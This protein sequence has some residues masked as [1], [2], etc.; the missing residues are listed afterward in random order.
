MKS[1]RIILG[2]AA[3]CIAISSFANELSFC[4]NGFFADTVTNIQFEPKKY[5]SGWQLAMPS[6]DSVIF[7][8]PIFPGYKLPKEKNSAVD[9]E[10]KTVAMDSYCEEYKAS[11]KTS[12]RQVNGTVIADISYKSELE[13]PA[14]E[15]VKYRILL[16]VKIFAG[17][18]FIVDGKKMAFPEE[19]GTNYILNQGKAA[20]EFRFS[21]DAENEL[22]IKVLSSDISYNIADCR[23]HGKPETDFHLYMNLKDDKFSFQM[24]LLKK[25][26]QFP[27]L[28]ASSVTKQVLI[29]KNLLGAGSGFEVG[30]HGINP[31][32]VYSWSEAWTSPAVQPAFDDSDA[33]SGKY[34]LLIT[35]EDIKAKR[36]RFNF[37]M[38]ES[39]PLKLDP[40]KTYTLSAWMKSDSD[41]MRAS[42]DCRENGSWDGTSGISFNVG[43]DWK[44]YSYTFKPAKFNV[45]NY[46]KTWAGIHPAVS[47]GKLWIDNMQLEEGEL[48]EYM[49]EALEFGAQIQQKHKL[50]SKSEL[51][52]GE[53]SLFF[54]NNSKEK[55]DLSI[56]YLIKDYWD[57]NLAEGKLDFSIQA[58]SNLK[59]SMKIPQLPC[60]Y[61]RIYFKSK[62]ANLSDELIFGVY[63]PMEYDGF[64][65][66]DWALGCDAADGNPIVRKLGFG[67]T[68]SWDFT[69]KRT[70]PEEG[71]LNFEETDIVMKNCQDAKL[72]IMPILGSGFGRASYDKNGNAFIPEWA[73]ERVAKSSVKNSWALD[74]SF[75]RLE[76]WSFYVKTLAERYKGKI[77]YWEIMNEPN[78]WISPEEYLPYLESASK[79]AKTVDSSSKIV[80]GCATSDWGGEPAPWTK[81]VL[82]LD[83]GRSMDVLSIHMYSNVAPERSLVNG[84]D[85]MIAVLQ[86][87]M[88]QYGKVLPVWHTEK[89]HNTK[90][91]GYSAEKIN[92]PGAYLHEP[93]FCVPDFRA[94]AE[95]LIRETLID[96][97][98]GKGPFFWFGNMPNDIYIMSHRS[99]YGLQHIEYDGSPC[100][101]LLAA[102]GLAR[103]LEGRNHPVELM[104]LGSSRYVALYEGEKGILAALWDSEKASALKL[105]AKG[106]GFS[107]YNFFGEACDAYKNGILSLN[108][109]PVYLCF[110]V[111]DFKAVRSFLSD[112]D[113]DGDRFSVS[114][115]MELDDTENPALGVYA[116]NKTNKVLNPLVELKNAA[117]GWQFKKAG[118]N[119][120]INPEER[121]AALF[122][123]LSMKVSEAPQSFKMSVD[124][125]DAVLSIPPFPSE[126]YL[127]AVLSSS[128]EAFAM[129]VPP[130]SITIDGDLGEWTSEGVCGAS[131][132]SKVQKGRELWSGPLDL[133][134][135]MRFRW[136]SSNLYLGAIVYDNMLERHAPQASAWDSDGIE[137]FLGLDPESPKRAALSKEVNAMSKTDFQMLLAPA[138]GTQK[139]A[140]AWCCQLKKD[141]DIKIASKAFKYGYML[142]AAIPWKSLKSD[143]SPSKGL[144]LPMSFQATDTDIAGES[145]R[146]TIVWAGNSGNWTSPANWGSLELK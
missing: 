54:R 70:C 94:K 15:N 88:A 52:N 22:G 132:S 56:S 64:L 129:E 134:C 27:A 16:P 146:K 110:D 114:G 46:C 124:G 89:S 8:G 2:M 35:A 96:S 145:S 133:S 128:K 19:K 75:P 136:D 4:P 74:V 92:L 135:E 91:T 120:T 78:C 69:F 40:E 59:S 18:E 72:N 99:P 112:A 66:D 9:K 121:R 55:T 127:K 108:T 14:K 101:E 125:L 17:H 81:R 138:G 37:N 24:A 90:I 105:P 7:V 118:M 143:F 142:E 130:S 25:G 137:F 73:T 28:A 119:L 62:D 33:Y 111:A 10:T 95:F 76:A 87:A 26:E 85:K 39:R 47:S 123:L 126:T 82:E 20:G 29:K 71:K 6:G 122:P 86:A 98:V 106:P 21:I 117:S 57:K 100:P 13:F 1:T 5:S 12:Y 103:M 48:G 49:P 42:L 31:L 140:T 80:G 34:S 23:H 77:K 45:L 97:S 141:A 60:G 115:G 61:Y 107:V 109:A 41:S 83:K 58:E 50:F 79:A 38:V 93:G 3:L 11:I 116:V 30:P 104:K 67:W 113:I 43:R 144:K 68:R 51:K 84:T 53:I 63:Q 65:P 131:A 44:R 102:N 36:G 139:E 32:A